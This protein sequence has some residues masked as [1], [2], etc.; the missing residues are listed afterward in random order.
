MLGKFV[1]RLHCTRMC[2]C[3]VAIKYVYTIILGIC[4]YL[5]QILIGPGFLNAQSDSPEFSGYL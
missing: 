4:L 3:N 1:A 5:S 2:I